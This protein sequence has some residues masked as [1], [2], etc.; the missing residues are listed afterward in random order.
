ME[1]VRADHDS[2]FLHVTLPLEGTAPLTVMEVEYSSHGHTDAVN[3]TVLGMDLG[4]SVEITLSDLQDGTEYV[5]SLAVYNHWG[6]GTPS[7]P[8]NVSTGKSGYLSLGY[9]DSKWR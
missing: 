8:I 2:V 6:M 7:E 3:V 9:R 1:F 4:S 5:V